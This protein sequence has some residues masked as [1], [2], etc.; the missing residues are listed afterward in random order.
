MKQRSFADWVVI[1]LGWVASISFVFIVAGVIVTVFQVQGTR[2]GQ[3]VADY[4]SSTAVVYVII[5]AVI[6]AVVSTAVKALIERF[7]K[8]S[9]PPATSPHLQ[10][11]LAYVRE[12]R[13]RVH[14][15]N[16][17]AAMDLQRF[18][19]M[20]HVTE[21][22]LTAAGQS[23]TRQAERHRH[24]IHGRTPVHL[25]PEIDLH[26]QVDL[27]GYEDEIV[28]AFKDTAEH[29][30]EFPIIGE[31]SKQAFGLAGY[32]AAEHTRRAAAIRAIL[33]GTVHSLDR[34]R[35]VTD[36]KL[37]AMTQQEE[38]ICKRLDG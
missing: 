17:I 20:Q 16:M 5:G 1:I 18:R 7:T 19:D 38:A 26:S 9:V 22:W 2:V 34:L 27:A 12:I 35:E 10:T 11:E 21:N 29:N 32:N 15:H 25:R 33:E 3:A 6:S 4:F 8:G 24:D 23:N 14:R 36:A 37:K 13:N 30:N 28:L 31:L